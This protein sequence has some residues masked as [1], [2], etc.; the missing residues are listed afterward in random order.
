LP[1]NELKLAHMW[2]PCSLYNSFTLSDFT[3][4][5]STNLSW[6]QFQSAAPPCS[7]E[8]PL[9]VPNWGESWQRMCHVN[10][11]AFSGCS[12]SMANNPTAKQDWSLPCKGHTH[13]IYFY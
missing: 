13:G 2:L 3:E 5:I 6:W 10:W 11:C 7:M 8:H 12:Y 4:H 1:L 9:P